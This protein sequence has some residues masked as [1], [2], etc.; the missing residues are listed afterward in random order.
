MRHA[1]V[2]AVEG[3]EVVVAYPLVALAGFRVKPRGDDADVGFYE[4]FGFITR[5]CFDV[6]PNAEQSVHSATP[7]VGG[8]SGAKISVSCLN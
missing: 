3:E 7:T 1:P 8:F 2:V 4:D 6:S 5:G